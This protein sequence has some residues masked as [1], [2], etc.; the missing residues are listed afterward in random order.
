MFVNHKA[1]RAVF[2]PPKRDFLAGQSPERG[3]FATCM[4]DKL[5]DRK[6]GLDDASIFRSFCPTKRST[7]WRPAGNAL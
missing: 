2:K 6:R 5:T 1:T 3:L 4:K 7:P